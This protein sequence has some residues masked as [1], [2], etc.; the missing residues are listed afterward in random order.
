MK[1]AIIILLAILAVSSFK[2]NAQTNYKSSGTF[3]ATIGIGA[4]ARCLPVTA[5]LKYT[6]LELSRGVTM[7]G[8]ASVAYGRCFGAYEGISDWFIGPVVGVDFS[9]SDN[10]EF[11]TKAALGVRSVGTS[12]IYVRN[13][14]SGAYAGINYYFSENLGIGAYLGYGEPSYAG[15]QVAI[16]F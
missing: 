10:L 7:Y 1:K 3:S 5:D 2:S 4:G 13:I 12:D 9:I 6:F 8:G 16:K 15:V 14:K 11:F